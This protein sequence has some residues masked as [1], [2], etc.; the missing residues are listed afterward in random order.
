LNDQLMTLAMA[1]NGPEFSSLET[2]IVDIKLARDVGVPIT[3][4]IGVPG[5]PLGGLALC[6]S[7][8][9][10]LGSAQALQRSAAASTRI[11]FFTSHPAIC[12]GHRVASMRLFVSVKAGSGN[13]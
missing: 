12:G 5:V 9:S 10:V 3:V 2:T 7:S 4:R 1:I 8:C 6:T 11:T 13:L